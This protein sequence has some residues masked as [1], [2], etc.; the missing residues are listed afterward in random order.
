MKVFS[1]NIVLHENIQERYHILACKQ[2]VFWVDGEISLPAD[3][4]SGK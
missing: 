3:I 4:V 2:W 1:F